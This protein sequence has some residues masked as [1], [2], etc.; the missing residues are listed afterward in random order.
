MRLLPSAARVSASSELLPEPETPVTTEIVFNGKWTSTFMRLLASAP[1]TS[2]ASEVFV[3][4]LA[5]SRAA[6]TTTAIRTRPG[7]G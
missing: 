4:R 3:M 6:H 2:I 1:T 7:S 5:L